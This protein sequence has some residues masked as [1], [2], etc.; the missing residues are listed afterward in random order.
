MP[1]RKEEAQVPRLIRG[2]IA[3][4]AT[5][6]YRD[7]IAVQKKNAQPPTPPSL[8]SLAAPKPPKPQRIPKGR[9]VFE[10]TIGDKKYLFDAQAKT[11]VQLI[12]ITGKS[13]LSVAKDNHLVIINRRVVQEYNPDI[14]ATLRKLWAAAK[15]QAEQFAKAEEAVVNAIKKA[16]PVTKGGKR[17]GSATKA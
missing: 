4:I 9:K 17:N 12:D 2:P 3:R 8:R 15:A 1:S 11:L 14:I 6:S 5:T 10:G 7:A 13:P 16:K